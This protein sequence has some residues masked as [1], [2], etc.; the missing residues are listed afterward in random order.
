MRHSLILLYCF[1]LTISVF[2]Q[3]VVYIDPENTADQTQNGT[4]AH[5]FDSWLDFTIESNR[6]YLQKAGTTALISGS[7]GFAGRTGVTLGSYN[8]GEKPAILSSGSGV[9]VVDITGSSN[10]TIR[11]LNVGSTGNATSGIIIDGTN[12]SGNLIDHCEV[13]DC[14]WGIRILTTGSGTRVLNTSVY[15]TGDD[16]IFGKDIPDIEIGFCNVYDVNRKWLVNRT[17]SYSP[18]DC[19]QLASLNSLSFNIHH[20]QLSHA[21][22]GNKFCLIVA[23]ET[24]S[25]VI[26]YNTMTGNSMDISSC[27]YLGNTSGTV[28]V[29]YNT[30]QGGNYG[31]YSY[32]HD[33]QLH[34]NVFNGNNYGIRVMTGNNLTAVNNSFANQSGYCISSQSGTSVSAVNNVFSIPSLQSRVWQTGGQWNSDFNA[35]YPEQPNFLNSSST[36]AAWRT[37]TGNDAHSVTG[38]PAFENPAGGSLRILPGSVCIDKGTDVG[39]TADFDGTAVPQGSRPDIGAFEYASGENGIITGIIAGSPFCPGTAVDVPYSLSGTV[40]DGNQFV[41][42]LSDSRGNFGSPVRIGSQPGKGSGVLA[43]VLPVTSEP[44]SGYRIRVNATDPVITGLGNTTDLVISQSLSPVL[45]VYSDPPGDL[46]EGSPLT[47]TAVFADAGSSPGIRWFRNGTEVAGETG[48]TLRV[49]A[50]ADGDRYKCRLTPNH[51]C[52]V[53]D[54]TDS[55]TVTVRVVLLPSSCVIRL[56]EGKVLE[57]NQRYGNQWY[58]SEVEGDSPVSG[59]TGWQFEPEVTGM[60]Y[61]RIINDRGCLSQPSNRIFVTGTGIPSQKPGVVQIFPNP[62]SGDLIITYPPNHE[63]PVRYEIANPSGTPVRKGTLTKSTETVSLSG[64]PAGVYYIR[65]KSGENN[66][67]FKILKTGNR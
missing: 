53:V 52:T 45:S 58:I 39:F 16:G 7:I 50:P 20:C 29:R 21:S 3:T 41:A 30:F 2:G 28:T 11:D 23:G 18:G 8:S 47:L 48:I 19:I 33:L 13:H 26:E 37:A 40:N 49:S 36:L 42:E 15:R 64:V 9:H 38:N 66:N 1:S 4:I 12:A 6:T 59:A 17:E 56:F 51:P 61:S 10:C 65:L 55:E 31:V 62:T 67:C 34:Y 27:L 32:V 43:A 46:C 60:Y 24:Y 63:Y 25:G 22:T 14:E 35:F 54:Y 57:S 5:P 44:G